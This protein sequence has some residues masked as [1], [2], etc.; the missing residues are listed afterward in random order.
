MK[1]AVPFALLAA[2][3]FAHAQSTGPGLRV[4]L[5]YGFSPDY[6]G[7]SQDGSEIA[8]AL[9]LGNAL[10]QGIWLEPA[11]YTGGILSEGGSG[12]A[13]V[14]RVTVYARHAF[15]RFGVRLGVGYAGSSRAKGGRFDG[16]S[17]VVA[18]L[19]VDVPFQIKLLKGIQP[20]A[21]VHNVFAEK[22]VLA[23]FFVGVGVKF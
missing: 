22:G 7:R 5:G 20:Y 15:N 23:G 2:S 17:G 1:R 10:G 19:G 9:P 16:Q 3:A 18:D 8:V 21:D 6:R 4:R 12:D 11:L 14:F 13:T